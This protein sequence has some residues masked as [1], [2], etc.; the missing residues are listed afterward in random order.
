MPNYRIAALRAE[1]EKRDRVNAELG[2][3]KARLDAA[4]DRDRDGLIERIGNLSTSSRATS[5]AINELEDDLQ[6]LAQ[7]EGIA[8]NPANREA[9]TIPPHPAGLEAEERRSLAF[10]EAQNVMERHIRNGEL[11]TSDADRL[12]AVLR[13]S[14]VTL[15]V[16]AR[17]VAAVGQE[18]YKSAFV[19]LLKYGDTAA[20]RMTAEEQ[21][22]VQQVVAADE[23][24]A[25][26]TGVGSAGG[27][28]LPLSIDPTMIISSAGTISPIRDLA[29]TVTISTREYR[30]VTTA[31]VTATF[32]AELAEVADGS[33]TL[34]QPDIFTEKAQAF[35]PLSIEIS[36]D[37]PGLLAELSK[38]FADAKAVLEGEKFALGAGHGSNEPQGLVSGLAGSSIFTTA[39]AGT[40]TVSD[41]YAVQDGLSPRWQANAHWL[42]SLS[43][44][45]TTKRLVA[46]AST[47]E[48]QIVSPDGKLLLNKPWNETSDMEGLVSAGNLVAVYGD[49]NQAFRIVDR[50]GLSLELISH[51]FGASRRPTGERGVYMYWRT[52]SAVIVNDAARVVQV[53]A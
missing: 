11:P 5:E 10:R 25:M 38:L 12:D 14:D 32:A 2:T 30:A 22:A 41:A 9:G 21:S 24:R 53:H 40:W 37:Y 4:E 31:G 28:G 18:E 8:Q 47:V 43:I 3:L 52:S 35:V 49:I 45:N 29:S 34:A 23:M 27:F 1:R 39:S 17:Y 19:K 48:P 16:D 6:R 20:L 15:G 7:L 50:I 26:Q 44:F 36:Q 51:L 46:S 33:P 42:M 13:G